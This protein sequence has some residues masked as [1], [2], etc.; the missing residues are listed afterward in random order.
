MGILIQYSSKLLQVHTF[1]ENLAFPFDIFFSTQK[2]TYAPGSIYIIG[3]AL[4]QLLKEKI[5]LNGQTF[6]DAGSGD[7]RIV[8]LA[9][10]LGFK[11]YGIEYNEDLYT[12]SISNIKNLHLQGLIESEPKIILGDFLDADSYTQLGVLFN[13]FD[14]IYNYITFPDDLANKIVLESKVNLIFL[15]HTVTNH[16]PTFNG[17]TLNRSINLN[18]VN[19][20]LYVYKNCQNGIL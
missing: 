10:I 9:S 16:H 5:L 4:D 17:L 1:F 7:G 12:N 19:Q 8:A 13:S 14:I 3:H 15:L 20:Y 11:A 2:G 6:L 18:E